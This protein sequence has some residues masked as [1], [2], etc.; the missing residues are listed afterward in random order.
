MRLTSA[1]SAS[2]KLGGQRVQHR[3]RRRRQAAQLDDAGLRSQRLEPERF[4]AHPLADQPALAEAAAA[5]RRPCRR[6]GRR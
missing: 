5:A 3:Q 1:A 6:T 2:V 4:D